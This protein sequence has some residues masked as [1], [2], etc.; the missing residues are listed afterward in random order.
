MRD[1]L[2]TFTMIGRLP[3]GSLNAYM[4]TMTRAASDVLAVELLQ[5]EG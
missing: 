3:P 4:I 2:D 5:K 1:V